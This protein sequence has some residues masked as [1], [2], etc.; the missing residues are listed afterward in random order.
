MW[1][2]VFTRIM[3]LLGRSYRFVVTRSTEAHKY[4][5][6]SDVAADDAT[7]ALWMQ[8]YGDINRDRLEHAVYTLIQAA[9]D[10]PEAKVHFRTITPQDSRCAHAIFQILLQE[11]PL[12]APYLK[13]KLLANEMANV[14]KTPTSHRQFQ[15]FLADQVDTTRNL[16]RFTFTLDEMLAAAQLASFQNSDCDVLKLTRHKVLRQIESKS[17][18]LSTDLIND[19]ATQLFKKSARAGSA[20]PSDD[21]VL[22][23]NT[24]CAGCKKCPIHCLKDGRW[25]PKPGSKFD[26]VKSPRPASR[27]DAAGGAKA[28]LSQLDNAEQAELARHLSDKLLLMAQ[29]F[30]SLSDAGSSDHNAASSDHNALSD[31]EILDP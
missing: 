7:E 8:T 21:T 11:Y 31:D 13:F 16:S 5:S 28:L 20:L 15:E 2:I 23:T 1:P 12:D 29:D 18:P 3:Q 26:N 14:M 6:A 9:W 10:Y 19:T 24:A 22:L 17:V 27:D 25:R 4:L 30:A